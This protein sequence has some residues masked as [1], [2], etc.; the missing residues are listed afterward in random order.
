MHQ[1]VHTVSPL[2]GLYKE[3][4]RDVS[5]LP[6]EKQQEVTKVIAATVHRPKPKELHIAA[7]QTYIP[8]KW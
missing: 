8:R 3:W 4:L 2:G 7:L 5:S 1:G 6:T